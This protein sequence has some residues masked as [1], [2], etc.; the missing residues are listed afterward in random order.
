M[1]TPTWQRQLLQTLT[2][3]DQGQQ[4]VVTRLD[5]MEG[6]MGLVVAEI[7]LLGDRIDNALRIADQADR[8]LETRVERLERAVF[9]PESGPR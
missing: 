7:R 6:Q 1:G 4:A 8:R 9:P 5:R 3:L 2:R